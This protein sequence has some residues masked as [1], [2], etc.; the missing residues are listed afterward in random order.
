LTRVYYKFSIVL[1][2]RNSLPCNRSLRSLGRRRWT[3][4][5]KTRFPRVSRRPRGPTCK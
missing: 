4:R 3:W 2:A 5:R 1:I